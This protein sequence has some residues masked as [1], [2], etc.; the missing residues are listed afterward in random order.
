MTEH[1]LPP[2]A[3]DL[4]RAASESLA[5]LSAVPDVV[6]DVRDPNKVPAE[7]LPWLAWSLSVDYWDSDWP[8]S[9]QRKQIACSYLIHARKGTVRAIKEALSLLGLPLIDIEEWWQTN[10]VG[11]AGTMK[12]K[13]ETGDVSFLENDARIREIVDQ[14][15]RH[16]IHYSTEAVDLN[17]AIE[18][19]MPLAMQAAVRQQLVAVGELEQ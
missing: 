10:P 13:Y 2:N 12:I 18:V 17:I 11:N 9:V 16:S 8:E 15:K 3:T 1:L 4:E 6:R 5:R 14:V 19:E 7:L